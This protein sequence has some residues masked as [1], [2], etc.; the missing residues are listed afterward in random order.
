MNTKFENIKPAQA[1]LNDDILFIGMCC[2]TID[3]FNRYLA[4]CHKGKKCV[5]AWAGL[6]VWCWRNPQN[7][8][9]N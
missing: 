9:F 6:Q 1:V 5:M 4:V 3:D 7:F 2:L 8:R